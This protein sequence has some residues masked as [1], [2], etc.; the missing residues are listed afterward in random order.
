[1]FLINVS[2][3]LKF[4][5]IHEKKRKKSHIKT[6]SFCLQINTDF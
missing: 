3:L 1:M 5:F 2:N 6:R 4:A